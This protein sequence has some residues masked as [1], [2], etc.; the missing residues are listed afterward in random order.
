MKRRGIIALCASYL[1]FALSP[2]FELISHSHAHGDRPHHH[3]FL[4]AHDVALEREVLNASI[5]E[6]S[7][8]EPN[9]EI[10]RPNADAAKPPQ[11][12]RLPQG[13]SGLKE[14]GWGVHSH[15]QEDPNIAALGITASEVRLVIT[16]LLRQEP[17]VACTTDRPAPRA[18]ARAPPARA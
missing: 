17:P 5:P 2:H 4:S 8:A 3:H 16:P 18:G 9:A 12:S 1:L 10:E 14:G 7:G 15:G 6:L 11:G 13:T